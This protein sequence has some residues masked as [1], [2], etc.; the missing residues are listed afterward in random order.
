MQ[1]T[2]QP[3][4]QAIV[5]QAWET[6]ELVKSDVSTATQNTVGPGDDTVVGS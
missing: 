6:P 3:A 1:H 2:E 5:Q 4:E